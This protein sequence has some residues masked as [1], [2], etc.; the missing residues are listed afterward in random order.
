MEQLNRSTKRE[1][2]RMWRRVREGAVFCFL[3]S[4]RAVK[5]IQ[6]KLLVSVFDIK[7]ENENLFV[8][9]Q[10][11]VVPNSTNSKLNIQLKNKATAL[12]TQQI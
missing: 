4:F 10:V 7:K 8:S 1:L 2:F 6:N 3:I 11:I 12:N 9:R 5:N